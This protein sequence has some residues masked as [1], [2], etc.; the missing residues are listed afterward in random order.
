MNDRPTG[1]LGRHPRLEW[2]YLSLIWTPQKKLETGNCERVRRVSIKI[3]QQFPG[4][5]TL[6]SVHYSEHKTGIIS[7]ST[8]KTPTGPGCGSDDSRGSIWGSVMSL[9]LSAADGQGPGLLRMQL[10][11]RRGARRRVLRSFAGAPGIKFHY[12]WLMR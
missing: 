10:E 7:P 8:S 1:W 11:M 4:T 2:A 3:S 6:A 9:C 5:T 12:D